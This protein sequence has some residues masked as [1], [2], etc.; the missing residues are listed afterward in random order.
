MKY[1]VGPFVK[2]FGPATATADVQVIE[3]A[4]GEQFDDDTI[5]FVGKKIIEDNQ[6]FFD[7]MDFNGHQTFKLVLNFV[8]EGNLAVFTA[9]PIYTKNFERSDS[10]VSE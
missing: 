7:I 2:T 5:K 10:T 8:Y 1:T 4:E 6:F 9:A 3:L